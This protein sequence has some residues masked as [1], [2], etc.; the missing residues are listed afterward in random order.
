MEP[1]G[2]TAL[3][4]NVIKDMQSIDLTSESYASGIITTVSHVLSWILSPVILPVYGIIL[5]FSLSMLSYVPT[6]GKLQIIGIVFGLTALLPGM[7]IF[8]MSRY[9][10]VKDVALTRRSDRPIPY[11]LIG[12]AL[13]GCGYYLSTTGL[14]VWVSLFYIGAAVAAA[15]NLIVNFWWKIS[16]HGAGMG[17]FIAMIMLMNRYGLPHYNLWIWCIGAVLAGGLLG[18]ARV[19]LGR[20]TPM[21]T[22]AGEVSGIICVLAMQWLMPL[23]S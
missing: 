23:Q 7:A 18:M 16:A 20:H 10:G 8:I 17:G 21:Q 2:G 22:V 3:N 15:V 1:D 5:V 13:L 14:P 11:I 9:G 6:A 12:C 19:W 4:H